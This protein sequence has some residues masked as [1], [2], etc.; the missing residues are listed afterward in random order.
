MLTNKMPYPPKDGG[1]IATFNMAL[2]LADQGIDI[3]F[4]SMNTKKHYFDPD[5]IPVNIL[6]KIK[7]ETVTIDTTIS[8]FDAAVNLLFSRKPYNAIRFESKAFRQKLI[9]MIKSEDYDI[10]QLEGL[11]LQPYVKTIRKYSKAKI[12]MR[13][14][15]VEHEIWH[16]LSVQEEEPLRK[17]YK[18]IISRRVARMEVK[19]L[20]TYDMFIPITNRDAKKFNN[21]GN[22]KPTLV[23]PVGMSFDGFKTDRTRIDQNAVFHLGALDWGPNQ[24]GLE[25]FLVEVWPR[26]VIPFP[27]VKLYVAGRNAPQWM[28]DFLRYPNVEYVGEV[29]D[30]YEFM[31]TKS[32]MIV[33]LLSGGGMRVKIV[34]GMALGKTIIT[35]SLGLEG[36]DCMEGRDVKVADTSDE[37][38]EGLTQLI[39]DDEACLEMGDSARRYARYAFD[40]EYIIKELIE[41]YSE[42]VS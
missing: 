13:S 26:I 7:F 42:N 41:F 6:N 5:K 4:L 9:E 2:G 36:V 15:N 1:S 27:Q 28:I 39:L 32:I 23:S 30:A 24:E 18:R 3:T 10:I 35:T 14:H 22:E 34:E 20:N 21:L 16:R 40:N 31:N 11:Y 38:V 33:P 25:W 8:K 37:F 17:M 19:H 12:A 29:E